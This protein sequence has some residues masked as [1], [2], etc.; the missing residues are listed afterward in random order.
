MSKEKVEVE[1]AVEV[2][3]K[4][5]VKVTADGFHPT[6]VQIKA[7]GTVH[8]DF[9]VDNT[10]VKADDGWFDSGVQKKTFQFVYSFTHPGEHRYHN[11]CQPHQFGFVSV[12]E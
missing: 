12:V 3:T 6:V 9:T 5:D 1:K 2:P 4:A 7:G 8:W 10:S 11:D